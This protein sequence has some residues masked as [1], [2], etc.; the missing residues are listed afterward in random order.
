MSLGP[1]LFRAPVRRSSAAGAAAAGLVAALALTGAPAAH[2]THPAYPAPGQPLRAEQPDPSTSMV[3]KDGEELRVATL[4]AGLTERDAEMLLAD[5]RDGEDAAAETVAATAQTAD[6]DVLVLTGVTLDE[7]GAIAEALN[8]E[9]LSQ[10]QRGHQGLALDHV[11]TAETNS[12]AG[13]GTDL[14]GDGRIGGPGD[15]LGWGSHS[16]QEGMIVLSSVPIERDAVRTFGD[17]RWVQMPDNSMPDTFETPLQ[18]AVPPVS[19]T[20]LWDVPLEVG[21]EHLHLIATASTA[22]RSDR[23]IDAFRAID[24]RRMLVDYVSGAAGEGW[25]LTDDD[26]EVGGLS[27]GSSFVVAGAPA[28]A[29]TLSALGEDAPSA[30]REA[31]EERPLL[32]ADVVQDP[33]PR[34]VTDEPVEE[35][36]DAH[37][38]SAPTD[39]RALADGQG[40][41]A[42]YVLPDADLSVRDSGI[43]WPAADE[44]GAGLVDPDD[45]ETPQDRLVWTDISR[46]SLDGDD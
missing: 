45:D 20:S 1:R 18:R 31:A 10:G 3:A 27:A 33:E 28:T 6:P 21:E 36:D 14:D 40:M 41:R 46:D 42:S 37:A 34:P 23:R 19:S 44:Y 29:E 22:P 7:E 26:G 38:G 15:R 5:L 24:E 9:Y 32:D 35:R 25:Y 16:G 8:A 4:E 11:F 13:S 2:A 12:G 39:T 43:F 17:F 30:V